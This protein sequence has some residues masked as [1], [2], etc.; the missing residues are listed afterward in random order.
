MP[1]L[2][3]NQRAIDGLGA[4]ANKR[5]TYRSEVVLGLVL[6]VM[7]SG[8]RSWRLRYRTAGGRR[9]R[10]RACTIGD[11]KVIKLGP[12]VDKARELLAA[13]QLEGRDPQQSRH[14]GQSFEALFEDWLARHAKVKKKS[15]QHDEDMFHRHL[16]A[17]IGHRVAEDIKRPEIVALLDTLTKSATGIQAN[18]VRALLSAIFNWAVNMG[19]FEVAPTYRIPRQVDEEP[20]ERTLTNAEIAAFWHGLEN[21]PVGL[22]IEQI[23]RLALITGQRRTEIA[24]AEIAELTLESGDPAWTIAG[25][26]TK[27]GVLHRLPLTPMALDIFTAATTTTPKSPYVFL[28]DSKKRPNKESDS[29]ADTKKKKGTIDPHAVTRAMK[30]VTTK[31]GIPNATVHDL[32][33]T[34]GTNLARLGVTKDVRAR[35]LNHVDGARSVTDAVYNQHEYWPEKRAGLLLW[36][37]E[38]RR[39]VGLES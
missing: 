35:I 29:K 32:R 28:G 2:P 7:P 8:S 22:R 33:R 34:V 37:A 12:A 38:L 23:L 26:R 36:E 30:R 11:A 20:R 27:N 3:H 15:W 19:R 39:I 25:A 31:L 4:V 1:I 24:E 10:T 9:G 21:G 6:E 16:K 17:R 14:S 18:R 13:V 5:T